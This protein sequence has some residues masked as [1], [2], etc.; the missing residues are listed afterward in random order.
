MYVF[1]SLS[2]SLP[3]FTRPS[4]K[5]G[6]IS[7][8]LRHEGKIIAGGVGFLLSRRHCC[9]QKTCQPLSERSGFSGIKTD[10]A[11]GKK[12]TWSRRRTVEGSRFDRATSGEGDGSGS[13]DEFNEAII[14][15]RNERPVHASEKHRRTRNSRGT[16]G[17]R[18]KV[19]VKGGGPWCAGGR[20]RR[21][22]CG[23]DSAVRVVLPG[24]HFSPLGRRPS[25]RI[26]FSFSSYGIFT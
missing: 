18:R 4:S 8:F 13:N 11:P 16:S 12:R 3:R 7:L 26:T 10:A 1:L 5:P 25:W 20:R 14:I 21:E 15:R 9:C 19:T 17:R 24:I 23:T 22:L 6:R 2:L